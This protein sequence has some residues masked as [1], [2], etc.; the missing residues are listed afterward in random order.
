M[1]PPAV[2]ELKAFV[3]A[4]DFERSKRFYTAL[5]FTCQWTAGEL[6]CFKLGT[7]A[8]FLLQDFHVPACTENFKMH[9]LVDDVD[10][11]WRH[12]M[13][14]ARDFGLR[15]DPPEDRPWGLRDFPLLDPSGVLWR[16]GQPLARGG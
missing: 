14:V 4:S 9:L 1:T 16:I 12:A 2:R 3:P 8:A 7:S 11:W 10:A 5:G 6:A 15:I 13:P